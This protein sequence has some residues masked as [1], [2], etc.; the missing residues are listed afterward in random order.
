MTD[1]SASDDSEEMLGGT[2]TCPSRSMGTDISLGPDTIT[3]LE[4]AR[5]YVGVSLAGAPTLP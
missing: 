4:S 5:I 3:K 1:Y 2:A